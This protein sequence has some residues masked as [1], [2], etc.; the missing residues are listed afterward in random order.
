MTV[1]PL[2][3][4]PLGDVLSLLAGVGGGDDRGEALLLGITS[5][6]P[7]KKP[8][9]SSDRFLLQRVLDERKLAVVTKLKIEDLLLSC[10]EL[11]CVLNSLEHP[12]AGKQDYVVRLALT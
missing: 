3:T 1:V 10:V 9:R 6:E 7:P 12:H 11:A 2:A 8:L 4:G 5:Q